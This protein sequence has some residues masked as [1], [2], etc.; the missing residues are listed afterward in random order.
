MF[1][2]LCLCFVGNDPGF[3]G[4]PGTP[5]HG[6]R[7]GDELKTKSLLRFSC[8]M[9]YQLRGSPE[10]TCLLNGSWSGLQPVCEGEYVQAIKSTFTLGTTY[11][12]IK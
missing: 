10:R 8:E 11:F 2:H 5:A 4:D 3:C 1:C 9:G 7:L 6:S 12:I